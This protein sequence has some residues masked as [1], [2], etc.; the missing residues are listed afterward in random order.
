[1]SPAA[2]A[3]RHA[4]P[5]QDGSVVWESLT[6]GAVIDRLQRLWLQHPA[7]RGHEAYVVGPDVTLPMRLALY[8]LVGDGYTAITLGTAGRDA[9]EIATLRPH[10]I[11]APPA[12]LE[13]A[14]ASA[15]S[16]RGGARGLRKWLA[17]AVA[18]AAG[19]RRRGAGRAARD[20][21]GSRVRW[22]SSTALL[23]PG[24]VAHGE[25]AVT[26]QPDPRAT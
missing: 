1:V 23:E 3:V 14:G 5:G 26:I 24:V 12:V 19:G 13:R 9:E 21:P 18:L 15:S 11:V 22:I 16:H 2:L 20:R 7:H 17:R 25:D 4:R 8:A 10:T 6:H